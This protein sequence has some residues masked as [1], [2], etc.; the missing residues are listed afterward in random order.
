MSIYLDQLQSARNQSQ[1]TAID[2]RA[3]CLIV[4]YLRNRS[5]FSPPIDD[6]DAGPCQGSKIGI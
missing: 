4:T 3:A 1:S 5:R 2:A 6:L